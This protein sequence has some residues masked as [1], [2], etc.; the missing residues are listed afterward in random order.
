MLNYST[1]MNRIN[2]NAMTLKITDTVQVRI[3]ELDTAGR[4]S[5]NAELCLF[6]FKDNGNYRFIEN[7]ALAKA[8]YVYNAVNEYINQY[9]PTTAKNIERNIDSTTYNKKNPEE[10]AKY[11]D[12]SHMS[13]N[14][15]E[16]TE[17]KEKEEKEEVT[18]KLKIN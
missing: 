10:I 11:K 13:N 18:L 3:V 1:I 9:Y 17:N 12:E 7:M 6:D 16:T 4:L 15:T 2:G 5:Y 8:Y 14:T